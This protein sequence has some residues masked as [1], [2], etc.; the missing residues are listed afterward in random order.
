MFDYFFYID[1][2]TFICFIGNVIKTL[3]GNSKSLGKYE[4]LTFLLNA[5]IKRCTIKTIIIFEL[6]YFD[7]TTSCLF[8][9]VNIICL[10][11]LEKLSNHCKR[12]LVTYE[13]HLTNTTK[14]A[15]GAA[16]DDRSPDGGGF[17]YCVLILTGCIL[18]WKLISYIHIQTF[19]SIRTVKNSH[20]KLGHAS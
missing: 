1:T 9:N 19:S 4:S 20:M 17:R 12:F 2:Y 6:S 8:K 7:L 14:K 13:W 5:L 18:T 16:F 15:I 3:L 11:I 10:K